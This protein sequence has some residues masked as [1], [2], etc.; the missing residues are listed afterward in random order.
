MVISEAVL[1]SCSSRRRPAPLVSG[2]VSLLLEDGLAARDR[3]PAAETPRQF[4]QLD[5]HGQSAGRLQR[6][7]KSVGGR[8]K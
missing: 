8:Q 4:R 7:L 3:E 6:V 1:N 5:D 2:M